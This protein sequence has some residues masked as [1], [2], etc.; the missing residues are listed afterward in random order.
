MVLV[1]IQ[2][3]EGFACLL[4]EAA[5]EGLLLIVFVVEGVVVIGG[6]GGHYTCILLSMAWVY[7]LRSVLSNADR[8]VKKCYLFVMLV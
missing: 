7:K 5:A 4:F 6:F 2:R 1:V 3:V 8:G